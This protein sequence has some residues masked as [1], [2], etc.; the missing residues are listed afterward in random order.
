MKSFLFFCWFHCGKKGRWTNWKQTRNKVPNPLTVWGIH[1]VS[2]PLIFQLIRQTREPLPEWV[3]VWLTARLQMS[4]TQASICFTKIFPEYSKPQYRKDISTIQPPKRRSCI[5]S[6]NN[7]CSCTHLR[8]R[9]H[10]DT[11]GQ[12]ACSW[13][14]REQK[15][16]PLMHLKRTNIIWSSETIHSSTLKL[17]A[18]LA[19]GPGV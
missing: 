19:P 16:I 8:Q 4:S 3:T 13:S 9:S 15:Q 14:H 11:P 6:W 2:L 5:W 12:Q 10:W 1:W 17:W 18:S 7:T